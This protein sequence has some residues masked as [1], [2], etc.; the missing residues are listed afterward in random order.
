M[1][2][3]IY[4]CI[5]YIEKNIYIYIYIYTRCQTASPTT[6]INSFHA[7]RTAA[8]S[9]PSTLLEGAGDVVNGPVIGV[10]LRGVILIIGVIRT[11]RRVILIITLLITVVAKS[12]APLCT[13]SDKQ[14]PLAAQLWASVAASW[15]LRKYFVFGASGYKAALGKGQVWGLRV[16][17]FLKDGFL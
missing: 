5:V 9:S 2:I 17:G 1:Y 15:L 16:Q 14:P 13:I 3:Y 7:Q 12:H 10:N 4:I 6:F 8:L 11:L